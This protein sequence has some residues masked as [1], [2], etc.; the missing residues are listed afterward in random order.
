MIISMQRKSDH[1]ACTFST[2]VRQA[3]NGHSSDLAGR[4][5]LRLT[6]ALIFALTVASAELH[7]QLIYDH[8]SFLNGFGSDSTI[9]TQTYTDLQT[10]TANYL[11]L[12][13]IL[14]TPSFPNVDLHK[15]YSGQVSDIAAYLSLGGQHVLVAHSLGS[16]VA[17]GTYIDNSGVR[18]D[19]A[20]IVAVTAPHQGAPLADNF[21]LLRNFLRD[22]QRRIDDARVAIS[23][24]AAE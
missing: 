17:R 1:S 23:I 11:S 7:A 4:V 13:I 15:R 18:P 24:E 8:T 6:G 21:V 14:Q 20:A 5:L 12:R 19:V 16:L 10:S 2:S 3:P 9:W 22:M